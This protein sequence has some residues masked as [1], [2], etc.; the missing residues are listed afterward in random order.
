MT[1]VESQMPSHAHWQQYAG[2]NFIDKMG[3]VLGNGGGGSY[4]C[5]RINPGTWSGG[6]LGLTTQA[7]GGSGSHTHG[8][9][10]NAA[11]TTNSSSSLPPYLS[12][13]MWKRTA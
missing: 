12:V 3:T 4:T 1:L 7:S 13:Y 2:Y 9:T 10:G 5:N 8:N 11:P 6:N